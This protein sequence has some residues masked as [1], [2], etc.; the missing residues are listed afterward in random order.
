MF[1]VVTRNFPP[2]VGGMQSLMGGLSESLLAHG[3]VKIYAY[4]FPNSNFYDKKS[5]LQI[6]RISGIKVFRK[7][8]KANIVNQ[9]ISEN[10]NIRAIFFDHWKSIELIH[11]SNLRKTK[12]FCL[13]HSKEINHNIGTRI[14]K[15]LVKSLDKADYIISNSKFTKNLAEKVGVNKSKINIINP[16][17]SE[18]KIVED[19]YILEANKYYKKINSNEDS[20]PKIITVARL[21]K[22]KNHEKI[23]MVLKNLQSKFPNIKY[24][25]IGAGEEKTKLIKLRNE[26]KL[27][28]SVLFLDNIPE[29][30]KLSLIASSNLFLMPTI[31][32]KNSVEGFGIS[33]MEAASYG[34]GSIGGKDGG[35][36]DAI[37]HNGTGLICD[38]NDLNSIYESVMHFLNN[39]KFTEFGNAA[40]NFSKNFY[41]NKVVKNYLK[42]IN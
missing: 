41:W 30:L 11:E 37:I 13:I 39:N 38:G 35:A 40:Q 36:A 34:V 27:N 2:D 33:F 18:P 12:T 28:D 20:F 8:R 7:Y 6:E 4:E 10:S 42:L 14:N 19:K 1:L 25:S 21:E 29:N 3:P 26:L 5:L 23:L 32:D 16:G 15:R 24:I 17:I 9:F 22:R 31:I